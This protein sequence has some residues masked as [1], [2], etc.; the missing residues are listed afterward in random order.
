MSD[1]LDVRVKSIIEADEAASV[2]RIKAQMP[3]IENGIKDKPIKV[4][5][6]MNESS[7]AKNVKGQF[8]NLEA[9]LKTKPIKITLGVDIAASMRAIKAAIP[10]IQNAFKG[11]PIKIPF[12]VDPKAAAKAAREATKAADE[13]ARKATSSSK[14]GRS[15]AGDNYQARILQ[16]RVEGLKYA[17][18]KAGL[19]NK[20][21]W[22]GFEKAFNT[23]DIKAARSEFRLLSLDFSNFNKMVRGSL[24]NQIKDLPLKISGASSAATDLIKKFSSL[25]SRGGI[26]PA[27]AISS[28]E[29]LK[30]KLT[31]L[32]NVKVGEGGVDTRTYLET[33][34]ELEGE[35]KKVQAVY[36][37]TYSTF[38]TQQ[39]D[40]GAE[41]LQV[42]L[43]KVQERLIGM[44]S[45]W[46]K[47]F[48]NQD[49]RNEWQGLFDTATNGSVKTEAQM[50]LLTQSIGVMSEKI[51]GAGLNQK[52]FWGQM[53]QNFQ[54][55]T[56]WFAVGTLVAGATREIRAMIDAVKAVDVQMTELRKVTDETSATYDK[57]FASA[58][59]RAVELAT[60]LDKYIGTVAD[61]SR[62]GYDIASA[63]KLADVATIYYNV[64]DGIQSM[65]ESSSSVIS[66]L[67]A[68]N[69]TADQ[70]TKIIDIFNE[71]GKVC[72]RL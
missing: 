44:R 51:K 72:C 12:V 49:L 34:R 55:F 32:A 65:E 56:Q 62:M 68:F 39:I 67:K 40:I 46:G 54:K 59:K 16:K 24:D 7:S 70:S 8:K 19:P 14:G 26:I 60:S 57:F 66:T 5:V 15:V 58:S 20:L 63:Q 36:K 3:S 13:A 27:D 11:A 6:E 1:E 42:S 38:R 18:S 21:D 64:G 30:G 28:I 50:R 52:T 33:F 23:G 17:E 29:S 4:S 22:S 45:L 37:E 25:Q 10:E 61:F 69:M 9:A 53:S 43:K 41:K 31:E 2:K 48:K 47:A 71:V 35:L